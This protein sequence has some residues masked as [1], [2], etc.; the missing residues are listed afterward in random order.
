[1]EFMQTRGWGGEQAFSELGGENMTWL[2]LN[3]EIGQPFPPLSLSGFVL[4]CAR[5]GPVLA[6]INE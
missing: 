6:L 4:M 3:T 1:M 2:I 5:L